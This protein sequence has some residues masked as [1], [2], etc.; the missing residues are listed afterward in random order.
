MLFPLTEFSL[1][2]LASIVVAA[3]LYSS[4]GHGG[5]SG[6]LA[7]MAL[8]GLEPSLM[9]PA[10]L[11]M[12]IFVTLLVLSRLSQA[13]HFNWRLF[14]PFVIASVPMAFLGG[15]Y[16]INSSAYKIIVGIALLLAVLRMVWIS[17]DDYEIKIPPVAVAI[18]V[19]AVLGFISGLTGVG[20]GIFLSPLLL[21]FHWTNMRGSAAIAAGFILL[22][23]IAGLAGFA[24]ADQVWPEGIIILVIAALV[25]GV[26]GS[27]LGVRKLA[28]LKLRRMLAMVLVV[29]GIK[30]IAT[31]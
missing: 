19:G 10:A 9:K 16:T 5:A 31:A 29:A 14:L 21:A 12:N 28:P 20:G 27:E 26:I 22:N 25:G 30:M 11:T 13:G 7:V 15:A 1:F 23:S 2:F 4:V 18:F 8:F 6:Y 3:I 24:T 17:S